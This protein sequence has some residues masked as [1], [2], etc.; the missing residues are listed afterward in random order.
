MKILT[1]CPWCGRMDG[2][3]WEFPCPSD[4]CP[5]NERVIPPVINTV[6]SGTNLGTNVVIHGTLDYPTSDQEQIL[7]TLCGKHGKG[8]ITYGESATVSCEICRG[9]VEL[10]KRGFL[11]RRLEMEWQ[12]D[13]SDTLEICRLAQRRDLTVSEVFAHVQEILAERQFGLE[14]LHVND[15]DYVG[16]YINMG[17]VDCATL[18]YDVRNGFNILA[19]SDWMDANETSRCSQ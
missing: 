1:A 12:L 3:G 7:T 17:D 9:I 2:N 16:T 6:M 13:F 5:S 4:D 11:P 8:F 19:Y 14:T 10:T 15:G 18:I